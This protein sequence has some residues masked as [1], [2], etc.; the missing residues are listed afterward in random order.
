MPHQSAA[1]PAP[2]PAVQSAPA[3]DVGTAPPQLSDRVSRLESSVGRAD[4]AA[5]AALAAAALSDAAQ[6]AGPFDA[7]LVPFQRLMPGSANLGALAPLAARGAPSRAMLAADLP[8]LA[9][10]ASV[11][12]HRPQ[13]DEGFL[14]RVAA[15]VA[16]VVIIRR[17]D[18]NAPGSD[19]LLAKAE[20][21][22]S[23]GDLEGA[24]ATL[25]RLSP[26]ARAP[27]ADWMASAQ[28][29]LE[30][31]RRIAALRAEALAALAQSHGAGA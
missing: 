24:V 18:P 7:D 16:R 8:Q 2:A 26:A 11:A 17:I 28:R 30:I 21:Q 19:G 29:R 15:A 3:P 9:S 31:D 13:K 4:Q 6:G 5:A 22:A 25:D 27:L 1:E 23:A 14:S 12:A 20:G 10:L